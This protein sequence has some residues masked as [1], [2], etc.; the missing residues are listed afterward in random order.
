[1]CEPTTIMLG[2]SLAAS[3]AGAYGTR[4]QAKGQLKANAEQRAQQ[5]EEIRAAANAKAGERVKQMRAE[6]AR[7]RVAAGEAG[8]GGNSFMAQLQDASFQADMDI[9]TFGKDAFFQDRASAT[10]FL[11]AN[12][13]VRNPSALETGLNLAAAGAQGYAAGAALESNLNSLKLADADPT[14]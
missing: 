8:V 13:S 10:R 11:S 7:I 1:M 2:I 6:Q 12:A 3:A 5:N 14:G 9:A 4:E